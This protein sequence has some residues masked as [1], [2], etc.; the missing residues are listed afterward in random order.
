VFNNAQLNASLRMINTYT[1][2][3]TFDPVEILIGHVNKQQ[4]FR[5]LWELVG[6]GQ[7][8]AAARKALAASDQVTAR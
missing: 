2:H 7:I 8:R 6:I 3:Q 4:D 5:M 1:H